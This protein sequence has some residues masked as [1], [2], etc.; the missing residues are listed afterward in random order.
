MIWTVWDSDFMILQDIKN[1]SE[2]KTKLVFRVFWNQVTGEMKL[3]DRDVVDQRGTAAI[4]RELNT[5]LMP[6]APKEDDSKQL[7]DI[8]EKSL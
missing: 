3:Y 1:M 4:L 6:S 5:P 7:K 8:L 2:K